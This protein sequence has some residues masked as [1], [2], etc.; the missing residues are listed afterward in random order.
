MKRAGGCFLM[1]FGT[2]FLC[3]GLAV[4]AMPWLGDRPPPFL[5][6]TPFG[7]VFVLAGSGIIFMGLR[8]AG[9][10]KTRGDRALEA[11][12]QDHPGKLWLR[13]ADWADGRIRTEPGKKA[14]AVWAFALITNGISS[15]V[16]LFAPREIELGHYGFLI[17]LIFPFIGVCLLAW[18]IVLT[19]R[20]RKYGASVFEMSAVPAAPGAPLRGLVIIGRSLAPP[21][22]FRVSL[23]CVN[24]VITGSGKDSS[25]SEYV[26]WEDLYVTRTDLLTRDRDRTGV[27]VAFDLPADAHETDERHSRDRWI[28]RLRV[29]AEVEGVDYHET[30]DV[31]VF[32]ATPEPLES[33]VSEEEILAARG[34]KAVEVKLRPGVV[35]I[36]RARG[37]GTEF[38]FPP[39]RNPASAVVCTVFCLLIGG[40]GVAVAVFAPWFVGV[41]AGTICGGLALLL[42]GLS[43]KAWFGSSRVVIGRGTV[44]VESRVLGIGSTKSV[45]VAQV[46]GVS[47]VNE[48]QSGQT[49][50]YRIQ[51]DGGAKPVTVVSTLPD[52]LEAEEIAARLWRSIRGA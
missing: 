14:L 49:P 36:G 18:A 24:V 15:P 11:A 46:A 28:W 2:P 10:V 41:V 7:L 50:M 34:G 43:M 12:R 16:L 39:L 22:G 47:A 3:A 26:R 33:R 52:K 17:A 27:A 8:E 40:I 35:R 37:G 38:Y 30:F 23:Q 25:T 29:V 32:R 20:W 21:D 31:P 45:P 19:E 4:M 13:K 51:L 5:F 1:C 9:V 48:G 6:T 42:F 44:T